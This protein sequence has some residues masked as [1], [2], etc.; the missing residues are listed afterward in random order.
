MPR[1]LAYLTAI[2]ALFSPFCAFALDDLVLQAG[3][4]LCGAAIAQ[5]EQK[6]A[7][8]HGILEAISTVETGQRLKGGKTALPWP[9]TINAHGRGYYLPTKEEAVAKARA[10]QKR[11]VRNM[12][13]G[14]MQINIS[15]NKKAFASLEDAFD[16]TQNV[17]YAASVLKDYEEDEGSWPKAVAVYHTGD[18]ETGMSYSRKVYKVK[19]GLT[20]EDSMQGMRDGRQCGMGVKYPKHP[21]KRPAREQPDPND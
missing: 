8:P 12:A 5:N 15:A 4:R 14:C 10:F 20:P 1:T 3:S 11:H 9:W 19:A 16:P 7:I 6:Y 2:A 18:D 17:A 13:V 21:A